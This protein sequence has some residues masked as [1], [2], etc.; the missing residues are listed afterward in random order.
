MR[1]LSLWFGILPAAFLLVFLLPGSVE[2]Q[3]NVPDALGTVNASSISCPNGGMRGTACYALDVSCPR[4]QDYT[5][6]L[7]TFAPR[8]SPVGVVTLTQG[9]TAVTLYESYT[10]GS[11]TIQDLVDAGFLAVEI[12]YG[13]PFSFVEE[14]WQTNANGAGVRAASCRFATVTAWIKNQLSPTVPLCATGNSAGGQQIAEGLA[15]YGLDQY[16]AFAELTSGP[17]FSRTDEACIHLAPPNRE[18]CSGSFIGMDVGVSN[19]QL[20]IDPAYP[21][22]WCSQDLESHTDNHQLTFLN[23]SVLSPDASLSYP[24]MSVWFLYGGTDTSA[25]INQ[26][27]AYRSQIS[28]STQASCVHNASHNMADSLS[29]A[30][31]IASDIIQKCQQ[32][33]RPQ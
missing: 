19:A 21:S 27:E 22:G 14:G 23:D 9:G 6:Y 30:K 5:V 15:H 25:A 4:I 16:L 20:F 11:V 18:Y 33:H 13:R 10:Y 1:S 31:R 24:A 28:S 29:G 8:Q 3:N 7:K 32:R 26:G 12:D 2:A 17:P